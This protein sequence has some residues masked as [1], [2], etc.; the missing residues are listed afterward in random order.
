M[1]TGI[2]SHMGK[3]SGFRL[4]QKELL[5][6]VPAGLTLGLGESIAVNGVCLSLIR[7]ERGVLAFNL[8]SETLQ[9]TSFRF[10]RRGDRLN[11]ELP[12]T[13]ST[14]LGGHLV[15]GHIDT[16]EKV[17]DLKKKSSGWSLRLSLEP[18]FRPFFIPK[19]SVAVNGV[20]LTVARLAPAS[21]DVEIIPVTLEQTNLGG[22]KRGN[23]VNIECD[24]IGKYVYNWVSGSKKS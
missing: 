21:F 24:M 16:V 1:F 15:T 8:S 4:G 6:E 23:A 9:K 7:R 17:L 18:E 20:S 13:L 3:F 12:L 5:I 2:I 14:P 10:L 11:L 19:G 22:L